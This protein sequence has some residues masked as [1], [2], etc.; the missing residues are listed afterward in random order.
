MKSDQ[1]KNRSQQGEDLMR[2]DFHV[3]LA[4]RGTIGEGLG[5]VRE[6]DTVVLTTVYF[7]LFAVVS[8]LVRTTL[9]TT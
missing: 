3:Q 6:N 9:S 8:W 1:Q 7:V 4:H 2:S 5:C